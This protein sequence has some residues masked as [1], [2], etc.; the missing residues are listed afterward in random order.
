MKKL[1]LEIYPQP[2]QNS[3][4]KIKYIC[5]YPWYKWFNLD[6]DFPQTYILECFVYSTPI[7]Y[8]DIHAANFARAAYML[9]G[10]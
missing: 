7:D 3:C 8:V 4:F 5:S 1:E 6:A 2:T 10:L 9:A